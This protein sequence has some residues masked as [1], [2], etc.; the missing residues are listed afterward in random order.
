MNSNSK[1]ILSNT[2][3]LFFRT[4][5]TI[6]IGLYSTRI[7][8]DSLGLQDYGIFNLVSGF[9]GL[10]LFLGGIMSTSTQ[11]YISHAL[12]AQNVGHLKKIF[13]SSIII[14]LF[15][16][17]LIVFVLELIGLSIFSNKI[18]IPSERIDISIF[19]FHFAIITTFFSIITVP[20]DAVIIANEN[21][22]V[23]ATI[24][25]I[26]SILK[27]IIAFFLY[28]TNQ[29]RLY[30]YALL[31]ALIAFIPF[32]V[33]SIYVLKFYDEFKIKGF[34]HN[35]NLKTI[36]EMLIFASWSLFGGLCSMAKNQ[37]LAIIL[38]LFFGVIAN[39][40][41]AIAMQINNQ[42]MN[43]SLIVSRAI[44]PQ[45]TKSEGAGDRKKM[46]E[47]SVLATKLPFVLMAL[48]S[49]PVLIE[50]KFL[51][52]LWLKKV[53]IHTET[54]IFLIICTTLLYTLSTGIMSSVNSIGKI[55]DYQI[56]VGLVVLTNIPIS[57]LILKFGGK[58][59]YPLVVWM[60]LEF[61]AHILRLVMFRRVAKISIISFIKEI[62]IPLLV[63]ISV[64]Y[65]ITYFSTR[66]ISNDFLRFGVVIFISAITIILLSYVMIA[67]AEQK[68]I[69]KKKF[70]NVI[71]Y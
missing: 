47:L 4:L 24:E 1:K 5:L 30:I 50:L 17:I 3:I 71:L 43:F 13:I 18:N 68:L 56:V 60:I 63:M 41:L 62:D 70:T 54:F 16:A 27:L 66:P 7:L 67:S 69:I 25:I 26:M 12:G 33:K 29:D 44:N 51:L 49:V 61:V 9:V 42:I 34:R 15:L 45:L 58:I 28:Y 53:P 22:K 46:L 57:Y 52:S 19:V 65:F 48:I 55:R 36:K 11:R 21:F 14:H 40:A 6:I 59:Y 39:A 38:N 23:T 32:L 20:F 37:G 35:L 10:L 8:L 31:I 2:L 64:S